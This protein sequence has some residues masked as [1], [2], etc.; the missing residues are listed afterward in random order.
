MN[1]LQRGL[2][3]LDSSDRVFEGNWHPFP[4]PDKGF[5]DLR[6]AVPGPEGDPRQYFFYFPN[7]RVF[8]GA[9]RRLLV[10]GKRVTRLT[11][12]RGWQF[13]F[14]QERTKDGRPV[15]YRPF[16]VIYNMQ[17]PNRPPQIVRKDDV[18]QQLPIAVSREEALYIVRAMP[19]RWPVFR[20]IHVEYTPE[21]L[22]S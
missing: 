15:R 21:S 7:K 10:M 17:G 1:S 12:E 6:Q 11:P 13:R 20:Q 9:Q 8:E 19:E 14:H 5:Y 22:S 4:P 18:S 2:D 3:L 16:A